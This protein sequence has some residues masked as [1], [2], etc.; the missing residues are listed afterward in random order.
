MAEQL[1]LGAVA[2]ETY[3]E[4]KRR[5]QAESLALDP[6]ALEVGASR[7]LVYPGPRGARGFPLCEE[8]GCRRES[9]GPF[10]YACHVHWRE[11]VHGG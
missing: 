6:A 9:I 11:E 4:R 3:A 5:E 2:D 7:N 1:I 10:S 8:D